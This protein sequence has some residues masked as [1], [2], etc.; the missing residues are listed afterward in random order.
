M[1]IYL[2]F[3]KGIYGQVMDVY[4][5][6]TLSSTIQRNIQMQDESMEELC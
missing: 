5:T 2:L 3:L 1:Q 6:K 4:E